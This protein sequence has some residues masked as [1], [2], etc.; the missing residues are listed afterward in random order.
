LKEI[1]SERRGVEEIPDHHRTKSIDILESEI[2]VTGAVKGTDAGSEALVAA[3]NSLN[4]GNST[5][6]FKLALSS[7]VE[8]AVVSSSILSSS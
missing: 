2:T 4:L 6:S 1:L 7:G 8:V 3:S 5:F